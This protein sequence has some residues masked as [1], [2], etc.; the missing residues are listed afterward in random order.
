MKPTSRE[1]PTETY[2]QC[3]LMSVLCLLFLSA[4]AADLIVF[5]SSSPTQHPSVGSESQH[6]DYTGQAV[7]AAAV[8]AACI[9]SAHS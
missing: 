5:I 6:V 3:S 2:I 7:K 9:L 8:T 1:Q 4:T